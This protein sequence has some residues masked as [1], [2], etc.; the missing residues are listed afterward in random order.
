MGTTFRLTIEAKDHKRARSA[1]DQAF[2]EI[3]RL[4]RLLSEWRPDSEIS[5]INQASGQPQFVHI[6]PDTLAVLEIGRRISRLSRGA[7]DLSWAGMRDVYL[8]QP[9][10]HIVP[11]AEQIAERLPRV[12]W[13]KVLLQDDPPGA[14]LARPRM[15]LG[16]GSIA[17]G[18]ALDRASEILRD[19]GYQ[20]FM[21]WG[22]GQIQA[23]G[24]KN[25]RPWRIGI[26]HPRHQRYFAFVELQDV[27]VATSGDYEHAFVK[28]GVR[29]HHIIDPSTGKPGNL[30]ASVTLIAEQ[31]AYADALATAV[32]LLGPDKGLALLSQ[33]PLQAD[34]IIV[35]PKLRVWT[36]P[37]IRQRIT[38]PR[39][40]LDGHLRP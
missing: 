25:K 7:Y 38:Y 1:V 39:A 24:K 40:L 31:G 13:Q 8:F 22:G 30:S 23:Y 34:A 2:A 20:N 15:A 27:A 36:S 11:T 37:S 19:A 12:N 14:R 35:D 32:F 29:W 21:W 26:Q 33:V 16:T 3:A 6:R 9:G 5:K 28:D 17:K 4:E 18:Y 10:Q